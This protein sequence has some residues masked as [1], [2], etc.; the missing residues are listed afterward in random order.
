MHDFARRF[1]REA[2]GVWVCVEAAEL[3]TPAGRIQVAVGARLMAGTRYMGM[4]VAHML[5][6]HYRRVRTNDNLRGP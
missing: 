4:D 6:E 5:E 3:L 2:E 1:M